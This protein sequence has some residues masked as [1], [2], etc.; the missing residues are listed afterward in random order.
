MQQKIRV[1]DV[2]TRL[3]HWVLLVVFAALWFTGEQGGDWMEWHL[4][5]GMLMAALLVF[6]LLWGFVGSQ[7]ARF[8]DFVRGPVAIS[9]YLRGEQDENKQA[10]HNPL[11]GWM[12]VFLLLA[13]LLQV[14]LGLFSADVNAYLY[15]GP[16]AVVAGSELAEQITGWHKQWFDVLLGLAGVHVVAVLFY[17]FAKRVD[18]ISPMLTG[19]KVLSDE[20]RQLRFAPWWLALVCVLLALLLVFGGVPTL[21][22]SFT[23][24]MA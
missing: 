24:A 11:G 7:T 22:A 9:A 15:D 17:R 16:L 1:W 21:A 10:G 12:V 23:V 5:I 18:L 3:F 2:P 4:R 14:G 13:L 6:R 20:V 8:A 19:Y